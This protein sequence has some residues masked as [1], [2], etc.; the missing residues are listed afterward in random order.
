MEICS[1]TYNALS[2]DVQL[3]SVPQ[4]M[5]PPSKPP[6]NGILNSA[7]C[8]CHNFIYPSVMLAHGLE[9]LLGSSAAVAF[10]GGP[11]EPTTDWG[12][13]ACPKTRPL[14]GLYLCLACA[15]GSFV[16][17]HHEALHDLIVYDI[18]LL[19]SDGPQMSGLQANT[20]ENG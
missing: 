13:E 9:Q 8:R 17:Q 2:C 18:P 12:N 7:L 11:S 20:V 19:R 15:E 6:S 4:T 14:E 1:H 16:C 10:S 3:A 5:H